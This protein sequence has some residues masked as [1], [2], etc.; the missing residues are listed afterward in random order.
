MRPKPVPSS[1]AVSAPDDGDLAAYRAW[2]LERYRGM[3]LIGLGAADI[4]MRFERRAPIAELGSPAASK[5][6]MQRGNHRRR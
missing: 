5:G 4:R 6:Q 3:T 2:A 1:P